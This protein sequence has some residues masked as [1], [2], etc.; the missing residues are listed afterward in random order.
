MKESKSKQKLLPHH[1]ASAVFGGDGDGD[2]KKEMQTKLGRRR[3]A[4]VQAQ[5]VPTDC[6]Q[7]TGANQNQ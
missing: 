4:K 3:L 5:C 1:R 2:E 6:K 7:G